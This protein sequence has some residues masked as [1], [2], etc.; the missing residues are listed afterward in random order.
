M[1]QAY[2]ELKRRVI[3]LD[4]APG[5]RIDEVRLIDELGLSRTPIREALFRLAS[6]GLISIAARSGF[7]VRPLDLADIG[8]LLEVHLVFSKAVSALAA[9]RAT[10]EDV[11]DMERAARDV[12]RAIDARDYVG[13]TNANAAFHRIEAAA[14][15][16]PHLREMADGVL[17]QCRRVSYV[18]FGGHEWEYPGLAQH[19]ETLKEHHAALI[20]AYAAHDLARA[21]E[22]ATAHS[23]LF[24]TRV[25]ARLGAPAGLEAL[26]FGVDEPL[27]V[28][29]EPQPEP[30]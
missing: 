30:A 9:V 24:R 5:E 23:L 13:F 25:Q 3:T 4:L 16:N 2:E 1:E 15:R 17:D 26:V 8:A 22:I 7:V 18:C 19:F 29:P 6:E 28:Q 14:A 10:P 21:Q 20:A 11:A 12:A 27:T